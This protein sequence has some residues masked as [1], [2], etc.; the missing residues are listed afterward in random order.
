MSV[1]ILLALRH[2]SRVMWIFC[3]DYQKS[4]EEYTKYWKKKKKEEGEDG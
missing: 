1:A 3:L 4:F 2:F